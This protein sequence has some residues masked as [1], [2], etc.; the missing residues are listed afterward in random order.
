MKTIL[1]IIA[2]VSFCGNLFSQNII[3]E[4]S[5]NCNINSVNPEYIYSSN[6]YPLPKTLNNNYLYRPDTIY[7]YYVSGS[8][9]RCIYEYDEN[10]YLLSETFAYF[11]ND[12]WVTY[13]QSTYSYDE[14][15]NMISFYYYQYG[16]CEKH[17]YSYNINGNLQTI[18][19]EKL[20]DNIWIQVYKY[21][22]SYY[23]NGETSVM[24]LET[25]TNDSWRNSQKK[26]YQYDE[27]GNVLEMLHMRWNF[28]EWVNFYRHTYTYD[29]TGN[30]LTYIY[31]MSNSDNELDLV[32]RETYT[33]DSIGNIL[34]I[35]NEYHA[36]DDW[37]INT[38]ITNTYDNNSN[39]VERLFED[40]TY[41]GGGHFVLDYSCLILNSYDQNNNLLT[42]LE[43]H[44][45]SGEWV[46]ARK[47]TYIY[48]INNNL[49]TYLYEIPILSSAL[50]EFQ[51]YSFT[52]DEN[53]NSISGMVEEYRYTCYMDSCTGS[54]EASQDSL[55]LYCNNELMYCYGGFHRYE[56]HFRRLYENL[57]E[58][59]NDTRIKFYP[60]PTSDILIIEI[61]NFKNEIIEIFN[62]N[63]Q[64]CHSEILKSGK[65]IVN[66]ENL[67]AG[68]YLLKV[69][70][71]QGIEIKSVI[72]E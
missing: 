41:T 45:I 5:L 2:F 63:G 20:E 48:D 27:N 34:V 51:K 65:T 49:L 67:P 33:Y 47:H 19:L 69:K 55:P 32:S 36:F 64:L 1:T 54:W 18:L 29:E 17:T 21:S 7:F 40:Y 53:G 52:Y 61:S 35:L 43:K 25:W 50:E 62:I 30:I 23:N 44:L 16:S 31:E 38:K 39:I 22:Y 26:I 24:L 46:D 42:K 13:L 57:T 10:E 68:L 66:L 28:V 71:S 15:E 8:N 12:S 72:I 37:M 11:Q 59:N 70:S 14:D 6:A 4:N 58:T 3:N 9:D 56:A 60:N